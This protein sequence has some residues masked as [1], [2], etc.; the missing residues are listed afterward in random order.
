ML[1]NLF[2]SK[3]NKWKIASKHNLVCAVNDKCNA[4]AVSFFLGKH[5]NEAVEV[6][7]PHLKNCPTVCDAS[8]KILL[9]LGENDSLPECAVNVEPLSRDDVDRVKLTEG[10][11]RGR[12]P[13]IGHSSNRVLKNVRILDVHSFSPKSGNFKHIRRMNRF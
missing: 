6:Y 3:G 1:G 12:L 9:Q 10:F 5:W 2:D 8:V 11:L 7:E 4:Q 13:L